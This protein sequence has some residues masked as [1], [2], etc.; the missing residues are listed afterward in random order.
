MCGNEEVRV[1]AL[2]MWSLDSEATM[3][4]RGTVEVW[5]LEGSMDGKPR[6]S[7]VEVCLSFLSL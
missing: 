3:Q 2:V 5:T 6:V 7:Q 1:G 4:V